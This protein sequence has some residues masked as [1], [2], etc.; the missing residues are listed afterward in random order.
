MKSLSAWSQPEEIQLS[1]PT[2]DYQLKEL[3]G[4]GATSSV[5]RAHVVQKHCPSMN[6]G[7]NQV[8]I[9]QI[10]RSRMP[11][12]RLAIDC[13]PHGRNIAV[14]MEVYI[15]RR[16]K[17]ENMINLLDYMEDEN[18]FHIINELAGSSWGNLKL[19]QARQVEQNEDSSDRS[20]TSSSSSE[21]S[22]QSSCTDLFECI[23]VQG[24]LD[25]KTALYVL[26]QLVNV[27]YYLQSMNVYHLDIKDENILIDTKFN[28]K[29][30]D[31]GAAEILPEI[32]DS[33]LTR[34]V[35]REKH[36]RLN[37]LRGTIQYSAPEILLQRPYQPAISEVWSIGIVLFTMLYGQPPFKTPQDAVRGKLFKSKARQT[38]SVSDSTQELLAKMLEPDE[39]KRLCTDELH[40]LM[41]NH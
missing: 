31:F 40:E 4:S 32:T 29:L 9:K 28:I 3:L 10:P 34:G 16:L 37:A 18:H 7:V 13:D 21:S 23:E 25:E 22:R 11:L 30:I 27:V 1:T 33:N 38:I 12:H 14:P 2:A 17:H 19:D 5:Y 8:A 41:I 20:E 24:H 35:K 39:N 6:E 26:K 36:R 15:M